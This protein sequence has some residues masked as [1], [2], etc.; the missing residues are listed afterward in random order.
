MEAQL[1]LVIENDVIIRSGDQALYETSMGSIYPSGYSILGADCKQARLV[2][3][4]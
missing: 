3:A 2:E 4:Y 1:F